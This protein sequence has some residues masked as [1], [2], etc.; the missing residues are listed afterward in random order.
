MA[1]ERELACTGASCWNSEVNMNPQQPAQTRAN[2]RKKTAH[3]GGFLTILAERE[4]FEPSLGYYPKHAFQACDLNRSSTSPLVCRTTLVR[5]G[6]E[7]SRIS[8]RCAVARG[9]WRVCSWSGCLPR[10]D[11]RRFRQLRV[12]FPDAHRLRLPVPRALR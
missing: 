10:C 8:L 3:I 1:I 2:R 6:A 4:G 9:R 12:R 7:F 11:R 5:Q